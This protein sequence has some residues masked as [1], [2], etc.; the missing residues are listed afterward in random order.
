LKI[1]IV[2]KKLEDEFIRKQ[3]SS[4]LSQK[5]NEQGGKQLLGNS[6]QS[7]AGEKIINQISVS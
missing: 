2:Y 1:V 7:K 4:R 5:I 6:N 3:L